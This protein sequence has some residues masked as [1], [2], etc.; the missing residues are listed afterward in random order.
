MTQEYLTQWLEPMTML[1]KIV[2][3]LRNTNTLF[4]P[5]ILLIIDRHDTYTIMIS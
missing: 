3:Y 1:T 5:M 4:L 2:L